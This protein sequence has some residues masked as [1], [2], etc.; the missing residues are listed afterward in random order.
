MQSPAQLAGD[1]VVSKQHSLAKDIMMP[2]R[3][4]DQNLVARPDRVDFRDR[5]YTPPLKSLPPHWPPKDAIERNLQDYR[6]YILDQGEEG[7]CTGF[8]L[9]AVINFIYWSGWRDAING[10]ANDNTNM[11][12]PQ[13]SPH[14]LYQNAKLYDE[15]E[16]TDYEG[17][18][19]RGAMKGWHK[20]GACER[21]FWTSAKSSPDQKWQSDAA[22]RPLGAYYRID[23][24]SIS[25]LQSAI[26]EVRSVYCSSDIHAG[27]ENPKDVTTVD[28]VKIAK[29]KYDAKVTG[30]HAFAI[31]GYTSEGFV[32]Q[33]S[34]GPD[35]GTGGFALLTYQDWIEHGY[36]AWV[37]AVGAPMQVQSPASAGRSNLL[38]VAFS[39]MAN[40]TSRGHGQSHVAAWSE[41]QAYRHAIVLGNDGKLIRRLVSA[42][43]AEAALDHVLR[44]EVQAS[45]HKHICVY[46]HGGLNDEQAAIARARRMGPWFDANGIHPVF[47]VWRTGIMESLTSIA[48]DE[49]KKF[50]EQV[51][52]IR[53]KGL[54]DVIESAVRAA[55]EA[56]DRAFEVAAEKIIGKAVWS[57]MKQNAAMAATPN[58]PLV[59]ILKSLSVHNGRKIHLL[60]HSAGSIMIGHLLDVAGR[61]SIDMS[62]ASCGLYAPACTLGF[63]AEKYG[64]AL[65]SGAPLAKAGLHIDI[66]SDEAET[67]DSVG[68][69]G[70][71]LLYLVS[72][73][74]EDEHKMPI[75][76]LQLAIQPDNIRKPGMELSQPLTSDHRKRWMNLAGKLSRV[77]V[78]AHK[79]PKIRSSTTLREDI[80]HG[81][82]DNDIDIINASLARILG[83]VPGR[84][85]TDL[86]GF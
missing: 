4:S 6:A 3:M 26:H 9:A 19:C 27:W 76:G 53:S 24:K 14:M 84:R 45:G 73:A 66:L 5:D 43:D 28:G 16:G 8:G 22:S 29:I 57:Q 81:T 55:Q 78:T 77:T 79:G 52:A 2:A 11:R 15:W 13:V 56:M 51:K 54:G 35:W 1:C 86:T 20:H 74:L 80:A 37:A 7:A 64:K 71:S 68:V 30:G 32:V 31:V 63:A 46:V 25:D 72:R 47:I 75:L 42:P 34:W 21:Q 62:F 40:A 85:V 18:S 41:E 58:G 82:F 83:S 65:A 49:V 59:K 48:A 33:N 10:S 36:D 61:N 17:S 67:S 12:P 60:G 70:K 69:Y 50:E 44:T 39:K 23:A 38:S